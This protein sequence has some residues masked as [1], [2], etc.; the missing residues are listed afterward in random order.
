MK[1][2]PLNIDDRLSLTPEQMDDIMS[3]PV[4]L[5]AALAAK[6][7]PLLGV[8]AAYAADE[9]LTVLNGYNPLAALMG[10]LTAVGILAAN[11]EADAEK[12]LAKKKVELRMGLIKGGLI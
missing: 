8:Q 11:I 12:A 7:E 9:M 4:V 2:A 1:T 10:L 3:H 5:A 6:E